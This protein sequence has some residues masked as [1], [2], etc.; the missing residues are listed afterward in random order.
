MIAQ[1]IGAVIEKRADHLVLD[2]GG[3]G[4]RIFLS[5]E[6]LAQLPG[7]GEKATVRT[8][9]HVREDAIELFGFADAREEAVFHALISIPKIGCRKAMVLLSGIG[10][11]SIV[12]AVGAKDAD[13]LSQAPG[14][15]KKTA[16][17]LILELSGKLEGLAGG[18]ALPD[19]IDDRLV[20]LVAGLTGLGYRAQAARAAA[21]WACQAA[22]D[23]ELPQLLRAALA[24]LRD[25]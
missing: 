6:A 15:G 14:V 9:T 19:E 4:Y 20:D 8:H 16:E 2:V 11:A 24:H 21:E 7:R 5:A 17:R 10:A 3:V 12:S 1:L 13:R 18:G 22:P 25:G 23:D